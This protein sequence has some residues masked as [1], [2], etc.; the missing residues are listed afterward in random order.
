M[1]T[2]TDKRPIASS[3]LSIQ[4]LRIFGG[5]MTSTTQAGLILQYD[6]GPLLLTFE[7]IAGRPMLYRCHRFQGKP[8]SS[9]PT[10]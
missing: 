10:I 9:Q 4:T 6:P 3:P 8:T 1:L 7:E 5:S 2:H